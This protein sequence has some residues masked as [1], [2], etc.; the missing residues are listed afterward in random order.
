MLA[1]SVALG[2]ALGR[3]GCL[4][5]GCCYGKPTS[6]PWAVHYPQGHETFDAGVHPTQ[7]YE[8]LLNL[9]LYA[10]LAWFFRRRTFDGQVFAVYL[11]AYAVVRAFV[12]MFRGDYS[13]YYFGGRATA[14]HL[15][16]AV[17]FAAGLMLYRTLAP[18]T[19]PRP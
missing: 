16:S 9:G 3:I 8:A 18:R 2:H 1:P 6:L 4:L 14:A 7:V 10:A 17:V 13:T 11:A 19:A 15:I 5:N 12:E